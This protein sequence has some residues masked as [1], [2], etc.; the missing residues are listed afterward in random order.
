[1]PDDKKKCSTC[2]KLKPI[3]AF[4]DPKL[5]SGIGR[6]CLA[7]KEEGERGGESWADILVVGEAIFLKFQQK[8]LYIL[9]RWP[10]FWDR[11]LTDQAIEADH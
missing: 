10:K 1:M 9:C 3:E 11:Q 4:K 6:K 7:C 8:F 5:K 2:G